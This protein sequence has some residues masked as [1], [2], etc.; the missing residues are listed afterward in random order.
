MVYVRRRV[1]RV[2]GINWRRFQTS[3]ADSNCG[4]VGINVHGSIIMLDGRCYYALCVYTKGI[5]LRIARLLSTNS[6][7]GNKLISVYICTCLHASI[8]TEPCRR[9]L[10]FV[11]D[12]F[13][14]ARR[15]IVVRVTYTCT[16]VYCVAVIS[17]DMQALFRLVFKRMNR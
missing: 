16:L 13:R 9:V 8:C 11:D 6:F 10:H 14:S 5:T 17:N 1:Y 7:A 3:R 12:G 15:V 4:T 2:T